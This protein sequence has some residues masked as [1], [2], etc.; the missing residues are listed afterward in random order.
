MTP[1]YSAVFAAVFFLFQV[2]AV[3]IGNLIT[4]RR[5]SDRVLHRQRS[6]GE[7]SDNALYFQEL[8]REI[9]TTADKQI[10]SGV[11]RDEAAVE[12]ALLLRGRVLRMPWSAIRKMRNRR[13]PHA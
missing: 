4:R 5:R 6:P 12:I 7:A 11:G 2:L 1:R 3:V 10:Q 13:N 8:A 9:I